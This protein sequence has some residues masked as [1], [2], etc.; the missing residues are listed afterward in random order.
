ME[1][2]ICSQ[3]FRSAGDHLDLGLVCEVRESCGAG[4]LP[5]GSDAISREMVRM[6]LHCRTPSWCLRIAWLRTPTHARSVPRSFEGRG[7][8]WSHSRAPP[9]CDIHGPRRPCPSPPLLESPSARPLADRSCS[10]CSSDTNTDSEP[11]LYLLNL[12]ALGVI[13]RVAAGVTCQDWATSEDA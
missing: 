10:S 1:P 2:V 8:T 6:E 9:C 3:S 11:H 5:M 12:A 4:P 13:P 7:G